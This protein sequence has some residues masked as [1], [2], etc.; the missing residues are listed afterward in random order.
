M[1]KVVIRYLKIFR[2]RYN[3]E[4]IYFRRKG[5]PNFALRRPI[6]SPEFWEDYNAAAKGQIPPGL[7]EDGTQPPATIIHANS[8]RWLFIEYKKSAAFKN[9][10]SNVQHIRA[11]L[12]DRICEAK[13]RGDFPYAL[14]RPRDIRKLRDEFAETPGTA[15]HMIKILRQAF[16]FA[17]EYDY[18][19]TNPAQLVD[20]LKSK[21]PDGFHAW[22]VAEVEQYEAY[23]PIGSKA[24]L[25]LA[26]LLY[27]CQR[28]ADVVKFGQQHVTKD[29]RLE[30]TQ[31]K[32][33]NKNP[34]RLS[35][36]ILTELRRIIDASPAGD[37]TFITTAFDRPFSV[38]GFGNRFRK[39]CDEAGLPECTAHGLR[40]AAAARMAE[41]GCTDH[42]IMSIGGWKTLKEVQRYT[43]GARQKIMADNATAKL[44]KGTKSERK[45]SNFPPVAKKLDN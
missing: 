36:P 1:P 26:I 44:E 42:E 21:N 22:T 5:S 12:I 40:K 30:F 18:I 23:H 19:E 34:V 11:R 6:G 31:H 29:G 16:R 2:D 27:T 17:I 39:W 41:L 14:M 13:G 33:R 10:Q 28:R 38:P 37:L 32:G 7:I 45:V 3:R 9:L 8:L 24:R 25:A 15:N 4:R 43:Q 35:I 20:Y